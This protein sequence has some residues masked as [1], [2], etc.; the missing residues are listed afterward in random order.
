MPGSEHPRA[1]P[2]KV[3]RPLESFLKS[4]AEEVKSF[5]PGGLVPSKKTLQAL[6]R[7]WSRGKGLRGDINWTTVVREG[8]TGLGTYLRAGSLSSACTTA[9]T[10]V[11]MSP[12]WL[13][14]R[15]VE[16]FLQT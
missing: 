1:L 5:E 11:V 7:K 10:I 16:Y 8:K 6:V 2:K 15:A 14:P 9:L 12:T 4:A 13:T 3:M